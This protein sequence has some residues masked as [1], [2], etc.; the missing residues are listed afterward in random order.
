MVPTASSLGH[1]IVDVYDAR[2]PQARRRR[3]RRRPARR[4]ARTPTTRPRRPARRRPPGIFMT[5]GNQLKL[6]ARGQRHP[7]RRGH[8]RRARPRGASSAGTSRRAPASSPRTWS[9]SVAGGSTPK[10][11]MTQVAAGLGLIQRRRDRPALRAAQPLRPAA[12]DRRPEPRPAR[13]RRRRGHRRRGQRPR[14]RARCCE[15][16]GA[17]WSRSSTAARWSPTPTRPGGPPR[18]SPPASSCTRSRPGHAFNLTTRTLVLEQPVDPQRGRARSRGRRPRS[19]AAGP[20]H[21]GRRRLPERAARAAAPVVPPQDQGLPD[22][23]LA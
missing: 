3:G 22:G 10:Q 12:D 11:R 7:V 6:S 23:D 1:E 18:C 17:A 15:S 5:G 8:R 21:R 14:R 13:H 2:V 16:S 19:Q 20:R 4:P 9:P